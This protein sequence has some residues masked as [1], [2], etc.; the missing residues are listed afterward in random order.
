[1]ARCCERAQ[2]KGESRVI[3]IRVDT[4]VLDH[5]LDQLRSALVG[6]GRP[7]DAA[8]ILQDESRKLVKQVMGIT[9]PKSLAQG[10]AAVERDIHRAETPFSTEGYKGKLKDR[11]DKLAAAGDVAAINAIL[12]NIKGRS[13]NWRV[14]NFSRELHQTARGSRG[15]VISVK[16]IFVLQVRELAKYVKSIQARVGLRKSGWLPA[17]T[18]LGG[19]APAWVARHV[20]NAPGTAALQLTGMMPGITISSHAAGV[21]EDRRLIQ[22]A[23]NVRA[24]AMASRARMLVKDYA[25]M[26][27]A[28]A[29]RPAAQLTPDTQ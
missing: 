12:K 17:L 11:L 6:A 15:R 9:P 8:T 24:K 2:P 3:S 27:H 7:G 5:K 14:M 20:S 16:N 25:N 23:V 18:V 10:R 22:Y 29:V 28:G 19:R 13:A 26:W 21:G 1:M 4:S